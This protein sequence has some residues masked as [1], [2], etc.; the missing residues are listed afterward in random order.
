VPTKSETK[1]GVII[2]VFIMFSYM[3][4]YHNKMLKMIKKKKKRKI[5]L[6]NIL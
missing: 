6:I 1:K 4:V 2:E 3:K 5:A